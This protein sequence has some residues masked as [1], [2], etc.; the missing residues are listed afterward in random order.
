MNALRELLET[1]S[2][3]LHARFRPFAEKMEQ[4]GLD[5]MVLNVFKSLYDRLLCGE[6]G[7]MPE[8]SVVPVKEGEIRRY[9]ELA[10][11]TDLGMTL[12][13]QVAII[14]LNGGLGTSM[15]LERAKSI[16]PVRDGM[17]FLDLIRAQVECLRSSYGVNTPLLLMNSFRT[18]EDTLAAMRGF[19]NAAT[20]LPLTF[21]Q[22]RFPKVLADSLE[23]ARWLPD[24]E[25]EWNPPGHGDIY[26][27]LVTSHLLPQLLAA[28][29]RYAF[30]S[31]SDNLGALLDPALLGYIAA[32]KLPF[33]MEV[34]RRQDT[35]RKGGHLARLRDGRLVLREISQCPNE[36]LEHFQNVARHR[37]FNTNSIWL[38]LAAVEEVVLREGMV[39]LA[40]IRNRKNIDPR[41]LGSPKVIQVETA[42][43]AAIACFPKASAVEVP[44]SR[45][46]P[47]KTTADLLTVMSDCYELRDD[48]SLA[49]HPDRAAALPSVRLDSRYYTRIDDFTRRFPQGPPSM[50]GC[51][52]LCVTGDV[53]FGDGVVLSGDESIRVHGAA[54]VFR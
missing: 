18:H 6:T 15:G 46:A 24:P 11:Y 8:R 2:C 25:L 14:K 22:N 48:F 26:T 47:V 9:G 35:D 17:T 52:S 7:D 45:F 16:I 49:P 4:A 44:R 20:G 10:D 37:Y 31:N 36:D 19:D 13:N 54:S 34:A 28:G 39:P 5:P 33:V 30:V 29:I 23:P 38:D 51:S 1:A 21:M 27:S 42:M 53:T 3:D 32:E 43:G 12:M 40:L 41:N 50:V